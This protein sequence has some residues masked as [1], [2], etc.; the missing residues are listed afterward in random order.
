VVKC[1]IAGKREVSALPKTRQG[2]G[3]R[4]SLSPTFICSRRTSFVRHNWVLTGGEIRHPSSVFVGAG[5][6]AVGGRVVDVADLT[7]V[8]LD[9]G[10]L[11]RARPIG[12]LQGDAP[13][14]AE[15]TD[16]RRAGIV[17]HY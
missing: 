6:D 10:Q 15:S 12:G 7:P 8:G 2:R 1:E 9:E 3:I 11:S 13:A 14:L 16:Q 17:P 4:N 5:L